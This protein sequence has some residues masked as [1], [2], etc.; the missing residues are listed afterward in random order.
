M[1]Y[2]RARRV[3]YHARVRLQTTIRFLATIKHRLRRG[4]TRSGRFS[5]QN[6]S[7]ILPSPTFSIANAIIRGM[8]RRRRGGGAMYEERRALRRVRLVGGGNHPM[9]E[10]ELLGS[11]RGLTRGASRRRGEDRRRRRQGV[12][13]QR[14]NTGSRFRDDGEGTSALCSYARTRVPCHCHYQVPP[15]AKRLRGGAAAWPGRKKEREQWVTRA[16]HVVNVVAFVSIPVGACLDE[17]EEGER[18]LSC[19]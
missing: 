13:R 6:P 17:K 8:L 14:C 9:I 7:P 1:A 2:C 10:N 3:V 4:D 15:H 16:C 19:W 5:Y 12:W 11:R 18:R